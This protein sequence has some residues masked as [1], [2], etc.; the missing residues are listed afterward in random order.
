ML[1]RTFAEYI[2][3]RIPSGLS[4]SKGGIRMKISGIVCEYN[5]FHNGHAY[6]IAKTRENGATHIVAVMSG[7]FVQRG[8]AAVLGKL[9]RAQIAVASGADLVLELPVA[10]SLA[11]AELFARGAVFLLRGLGCVEELSFGSECG[12]PARLSQAVKASVS[13][14]KSDAMHQL[15]R[16]GLPYPR[17]MRRLVLEQYGEELA[18]VF[19]GPNNLLAVE[20]LKAMIFLGAKLQPFT[21]PRKSAMH[22]MLEGHGGS[23]AS[24]SFIRSCIEENE[25]YDELVPLLTAHALAQAGSN[26]CIGRLRNLERLIL[27]RLRTVT[28][29]ELEEQFEMG[30]GLDG[31]ILGARNS[32]S[33]DEALHAIKTKRYPMARIRRLL[34]C[35]LMG[36]RKEDL[37]TPPPYG[38]VL[39]L[40]ER[41][42]EILAAAK[43]KSTSPFA[44]SLAKLGEIS[45]Q[46]RRYAELEAR[47]AD[48]YGLATRCIT[49]S[50]QEYRAKI[51]LT[52]PQEQE[53]TETTE[54]E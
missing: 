43:G 48:V 32:N 15:L 3:D 21:V 24:A 53:T 36:L 42:C 51:T 8:D 26:G 18:R 34:L 19:D 40:N 10:Y 28:Q 13:C 2:A 52:P 12:D 16:E 47:A 49:S 35:L 41:G 50:E 44:T 39:A 1:Y 7:N 23:I 11:P 20:Y 27:Y 54:Q 33:L 31:R 25:E 38:R 45:P 17:A 14:G 29:Q 46:A 30:P 22:D 5:P 4:G 6:H 9:T 37:Q